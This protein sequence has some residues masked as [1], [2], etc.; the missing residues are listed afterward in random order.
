MDIGSRYERAENKTHNSNRY[1]GLAGSGLGGSKPTPPDTNFQ[2]PVWGSSSTSGGLNPPPNPPTNRT[3]PKGRKLGWGSW[4]GADPWAGCP[5]HQLRGSGRHCKLS[6]APAHYGLKLKLLA[7]FSAGCSIS[8]GVPLLGKPHRAC[9]WVGGL[10]G[11]RRPSVSVDLPSSLTHHCLCS[12]MSLYAAQR[13]HGWHPVAYSR[14]A[15]APW[16]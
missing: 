11:R 5:S 13:H 14:I 7:S 1:V 3:L 6:R 4:G 8:L 10:N 16:A 15:A 2:S 12:S 9:C